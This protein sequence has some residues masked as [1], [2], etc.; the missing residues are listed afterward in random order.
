VH[1]VF[2]SYQNK[3]ASSQKRQFH[4]DNTGDSPTV[5]IPF[6]LDGTYPTSDYATLGPSKITAAV[7]KCLFSAQLRLHFTILHRAGLEPY[8]SFYKLAKFCVFIKQSLLVILCYSP[9][10]FTNNWIIK[11]TSTV[12]LFSIT[13]IS[14]NKLI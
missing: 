11:W 3:T 14:C 2:P 6:I 8:T 1:G 5:V 13:K 9:L 4:R 7:Y 12:H 10:F